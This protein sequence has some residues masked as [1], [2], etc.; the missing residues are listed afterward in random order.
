MVTNLPFFKSNACARK[1]V[2]DYR[3]DITVL[4]PYDF[5]Y[6]EFL[7]KTRNIENRRSKSEILADGVLVKG[8]AS[9]I[10]F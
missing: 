7:G 8:E 9:S 10:G 3:S 4:D 6:F 1:V 2:I 5:Q